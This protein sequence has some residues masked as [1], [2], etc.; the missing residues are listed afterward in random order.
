MPDSATP[1]MALV[2]HDNAA[3]S[4]GRCMSSAASG[5]PLVSG[6]TVGDTLAK[7]H[8]EPRLVVVGHEHLPDAVAALQDHPR[9]QIAVLV[10]ETSDEIL[11]TA[12]RVPQVVG[13]L[14]WLPAGVRP[15]ELS[16]VTRRAVS[17][18]QPTPPT[19]SVMLWGAST[20]TWRPRDA[21]TRD[22]A[23]RS[24]ELVAARFGIHRKVAAT[25]ADAAHEL[26]MNAMVDA[27]VDGRGRPRFSGD[28]DAVVQLTEDEAPTLQLT[29]DSSHLAL[30]V[31]DP[32]GRLE[33]DHL[34]EA[35]LR[36]RTGRP[37]TTPPGQR[38]GLGLFN[39]FHSAAVLRVEVSPGHH[40]L[41]SWI[42]DR[43]VS[44]RDRRSMA[45]SLYFVQSST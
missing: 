9:M 28:R 15:W 35:I 2:I 4:V 1:Y 10:P 34:F 24:V 13:L 16:Y 26:L 18:Q 32:F 33:R 39:L 25:A 29:V 19:A 37:G 31:T 17:P 3:D 40:T 11:L 38:P 23:I 20:V 21:A 42:V 43:G 12:L 27:P 8:G 41:V 5:T 6:P 36:G 22:L 7:L 14:A 44:A 45:R 30:D